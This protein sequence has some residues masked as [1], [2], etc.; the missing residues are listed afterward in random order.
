MHLVSCVCRWVSLAL[1]VALAA[2]GAINDIAASSQLHAPAAAVQPLA[3]APHGLSVAT[4]QTAKYVKLGGEVDRC[5]Y[6]QYDG[7]CA[8][9]FIDN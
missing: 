9:Q 4:A 8:V 2:C 6:T 1:A 5:T 3:D 7:G